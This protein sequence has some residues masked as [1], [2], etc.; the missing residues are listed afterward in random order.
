[1]ADILDM[2]PPEGIPGALFNKLTD[3]I[4]DSYPMKSR[5]KAQRVALRSL[6]IMMAFYEEVAKDECQH[7]SVNIG[8]NATTC[9]DCGAV[10]Q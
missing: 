7:Y 2:V 6:E 4:Y 8:R 1:M 3:L 9:R 10:V 5:T